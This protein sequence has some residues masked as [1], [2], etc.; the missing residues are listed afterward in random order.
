M[1]SASPPPQH[2]PLAFI[3]GGN[4]ASAI[5]GGLLRRGLDPSLVEVVE[6]FAPTRE[7]L[8]QVHGVR[9]LPA[10]QDALRRASLV[11]WAVKPQSFAEAAEQARAHLA[12][13]ALHLSVAAGIRSGSIATWLGT[14]HVVRAMPNTP[15]LVGKGITGLFARDAVTRSQRQRVEQVVATTGEWLW[16]SA[17]EQLDAVTALSGSGP[18]YVFLF[19]ESMIEAG[20]QMGLPRAQAAQLAIATFSG[21]AALARD[22]DDPPQVLRERVTSKGGTTHAA[23]SAMEAD[24]VPQAFQRALH[25]A[26][27]RA[28]ELGDAFGAT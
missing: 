1:T 21:S 7:R 6:P 22:A 14:E 13:D 8:L 10:A 5:L 2:A 16:V 28:T 26:C 18:A 24:G 11:V 19:L 4:M 27:A 12:P 17:E 9:A 3:G 15:A 23:I 20:V 25:A